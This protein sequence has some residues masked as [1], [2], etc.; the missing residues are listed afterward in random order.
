MSITAKYIKT[1][2]SLPL[3]LNNGVLPT[4]YLKISTNI[5][6][7]YKDTILKDYIFVLSTGY[8]KDSFQSKKIKQVTTSNKGISYLNYCF[9]KKFLFSLFS[10]KYR[11]NYLKNLLEKENKLILY[12]KKL[13]TNNLNLKNT[14]SF[15]NYKTKINNFSN[16][17]NISSKSQLFIKDNYRIYFF[18][19]QYGKLSKLK[20]DFFQK[21]IFTG[22]VW[23]LPPAV[24]NNFV[25]SLLIFNLILT[26]F[27]NHI[28]S[29]QCFK[30]ID[31]Y[32]YYIYIAYYKYN[33]Y[34]FY[35]FLKRKH[36]SIRKANKF[37]RRYNLFIKEKYNRVLDYLKYY[38]IY[39]SINSI[40]LNRNNPTFY[41]FEK[42]VTFS[43]I[44]SLEY[45]NLKLLDNNLIKKLIYTKSILIKNINEN[46]KYYARSTRINTIAAVH[47]NIQHSLRSF[48]IETSSSFDKKFIRF[49]LEVKNSFSLPGKI[50][51]QKKKTS[52]RSLLILKILSINKNIRFKK[53]KKNKFK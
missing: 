3:S 19:N 35:G 27:I 34:K 8:T 50:T 16:D 12:K 17:W 14:L 13:S 52:Y 23:I 21:S 41:S 49:P 26:L 4:N 11:I 43:L 20:S 9:N 1:S 15:K 48:Q 25:R 51:S 22:L 33:I 40:I 45:N 46:L 42:I 53:L 7:Y 47:V 44:Q 6:G 38:L 29:A 18:S 10:V 2:I 28:N 32:K 36:I 39:N 5:R 31:T 24:K 30:D 37:L